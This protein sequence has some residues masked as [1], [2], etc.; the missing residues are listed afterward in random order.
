MIQIYKYMPVSKY[1]LD[2]LAAMKLW[3]SR[4]QAFNDPFEFRLQR[5]KLAAGMQEIR[6]QNPRLA[7]LTDEQFLESS[8]ILEMEKVIGQMGVIC[9]AQHADNILMWSHYASQHHGICVGFEVGKLLNDAGIYPVQYSPNYPTLTFAKIWHK[10]GL[11]KVLWTKNIGWAYEE[12]LRG[13]TVDGNTLRDYPGRLNKV[14]FGLRTPDADVAA[15]KAKAGAAVDYYRVALD[16][17]A[18]K[19]NIAPL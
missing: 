12:E 5:A 16:D 17:T 9:Y 13:I 4:P 14:I 7:H 11:A 1:S 2:N 19:L 15:V 6:E 10:D 8:A 18:Y 3:A